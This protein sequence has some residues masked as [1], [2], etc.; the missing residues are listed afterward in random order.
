[1]RWSWKF[2]RVLGIDLHVHFT[3]FLLLAWIAY[4]HYSATH[5]VQ[6][7]LN[8]V[9][10]LLTLFFIVVLH[11]LGHAMAARHYGVKTRDI[12]LLPIGGVARLERMPEVPRQELVIALAGPAVNVVLAAILALVLIGDDWMGVDHCLGIYGGFLERL[13]W[14]NVTLAG[15]NLIPA[16]PMDGGR[17]LRA[18]LAM[19]LDFARATRIA[20]SVGR[21]IA[22]VLGVIGLFYNPVLALIGLFIWMAA[23]N[24]ARLVSKRSVVTGI[25]V[26]QVM[27]TDFRSLTPDETL[28]N[29]AGMVLSG[30]QSEFP[31][32]V[33][34]RL[35]GMLT[36]SDLIRGLAEDGL[37]GLVRD[38]MREEFTTAGAF[39]T[40]D[41]VLARAPD[42]FETLTVVHEGKPV[43]MVTAGQ[44]QELLLLQRALRTS[45]K[46][47]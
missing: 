33:D 18:L 10:Y 41:A 19:H 32:V 5:S 35:V 3:F 7:T 40:L 34:G 30:F 25:P 28:G 21:I 4:I 24:E 8:G 12:T 20:S 17:V 36:K 16:F 47:I 44:I 6:A 1:M 13:F 42:G 23:A 43:G 45:P 38:V 37:H 27:I 46:P 9:A 2:G 26:R 22:M 14:T 39:E 11:E 29:V 31:V 15:F